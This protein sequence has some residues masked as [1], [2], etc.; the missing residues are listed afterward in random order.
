M[1]KSILVELLRFLDDFLLVLAPAFGRGVFLRFIAEI[2][3]GHF[4]LPS[5]SRLTKPEVCVVEHLNR[6]VDALGTEV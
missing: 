4:H 6:Q 1:S 3:R 5:R 2:R